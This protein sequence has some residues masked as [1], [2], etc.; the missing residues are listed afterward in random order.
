MF[1]S[2]SLPVPYFFAGAQGAFDDPEAADI[3]PPDILTSY[4]ATFELEY[5]Q[6]GGGLRQ[7]RSAPYQVYG[8]TTSFLVS[9]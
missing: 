5:A 4:T 6:M 7:Y 9:S 3:C 1:P 2:V 8:A